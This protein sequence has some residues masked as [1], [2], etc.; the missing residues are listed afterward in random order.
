LILKESA[1]DHKILPVTLQILIENAIKHNEVSQDSPLV[2]DIY[3]ESDY[4]VVRNNLQLK[5][6][7]DTSNKQG[8]E[9]LKSL[10][11]VLIEKDMLVEQTQTHF[12]SKY[13]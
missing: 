6:I 1:L 11:R 5:N 10:Y 13:L 12:W 8:L 2:I 3:A 7:M 4:L 9:N